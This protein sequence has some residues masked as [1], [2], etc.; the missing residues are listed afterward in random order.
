MGKAG[1]QGRD[2]RL[3]SSDP[4]MSSAPSSDDPSLRRRLIAQ[5][6]SYDGL[7]WGQCLDHAEEQALLTLAQVFD[8]D[9]TGLSLARLWGQLRPMV[10]EHARS[11]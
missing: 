9:A 4:F 1:T 6:A 7:M 3:P 10:A 2:P 5:I 8:L 11:I